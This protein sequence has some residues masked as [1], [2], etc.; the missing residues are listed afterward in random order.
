MA[1]MTGVFKELYLVRFNSEYWT[2]VMTAARN[3]QQEHWAVEFY[4]KLV[5]HRKLMEAGEKGRELQKR[6]AA[7]LD[8]FR[9]HYGLGG[10]LRWIFPARSK[11]SPARK[12]GSSAR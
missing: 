7:L 1:L 8:D 2:A 5:L 11:S 9:N 4:D 12:P 3:A 6:E 10:E